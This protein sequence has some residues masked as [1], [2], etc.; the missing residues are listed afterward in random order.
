MLTS[1]CPRSCTS[2][3]EVRKSDVDAIITK[4]LR[5]LDTL[6]AEIEVA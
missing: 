3:Q 2:W 6:I 1:P 5:I 4:R